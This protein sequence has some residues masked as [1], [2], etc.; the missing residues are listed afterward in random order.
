MQVARSRGV[1]SSAYSHV[2]M[3]QLHTA[4]LLVV[5]VLV[6]ACGDQSTSVGLPSA[7]SFSV[8]AGAAQASYVGQTV[9][10]AGSVSDGDG[11]ALSYQWTQLAGPVVSL[12]NADQATASFTAPASLLSGSACVP[13]VFQLSVSDA[14]GV[15]RSAETT[16]TLSP[17]VASACQ[18]GSYTI[19]GQLSYDRIPPTAEG[20]LDYANITSAPIRGAS[21]EALDPNGVVL[22]TAQT[23]GN[24]HYTFALTSS[25][26]SSVQLRVMAQLE[27]MTPSWSVAV[28][29][30]TQ[31]DATYAL[32]S[33]LSLVPLATTN[34][35]TMPLVISLHASSGWDGSAYTGARAAAPFAILDTL[36][37]ALQ[38]FGTVVSGLSV[39]PFTMRWSS[40]N[41]S[42]DGDV[43]LGEVG[44]TYYDGVDQITLLGDRM[45]DT[46]EYDG[47]VILHEF[48]HHFEATAS[49]SDSIGGPHALFADRLDMRVAFSEGMATALGAIISGESLYFDS[50]APSGGF[51]SSVETID[52][53]ND[54]T[55]GWFNEFSVIYTLYD[56]FDAQDE[57]GIDTVTLGLL[58]IYDVLVN[59]HRTGIPFNSIFTFITAL[60]AK[61]PAQVAAID[62]LVSAQGINSDAIDAYGSSET[63]SAGLGSDVLPVYTRLIASASTATTIVTTT[64]IST[65]FGS[66][67]KLSNNRFFRID[68]VAGATYDI[69]IQFVSGTRPVDTESFL[70]LSDTNAHSCLASSFSGVC[71][72]ADDGTFSF[73][74][75]TGGTHVMSLYEYFERDQGTGNTCYTVTALR[76]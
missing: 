12:S 17:T 45:A 40:Q 70:I 4:L 16:V 34:V 54:A 69:G 20:A 57:A 3:R 21:V 63:N 33:L 32:V 27:S 72:Q 71:A 26:A 41:T 9:S 55:K 22:A 47:P 10:L 42:I 65:E 76:R 5:A 59:E 29:D 66:Y 64:C 56:L 58:P 31:S 30:N 60:K 44:G 67:D 2:A 48:G 24:G 73:R 61:Q 15:T 7:L 50:V 37:G 28:L 52:S 11:S 38:R 18:A 1:S 53:R 19:T 25:A 13:L 35:V 46:D 8:D 39:V 43:A 62:V 14:D 74:S 36:Y 23:D 75:S 68:T 49:R 51:V 6:S